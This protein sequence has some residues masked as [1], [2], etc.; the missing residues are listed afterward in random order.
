M[1]Y[2]GVLFIFFVFVGVNAQIQ[3]DVSRFKKVTKFKVRDIDDYQIVSFKIRDY[4]GGYT[5]L[6]DEDGEIVPHRFE[7]S[8]KTIDASLIRVEKVSSKKR[9]NLQD[10]VDGNINTSLI[11]DS[12]KDSVHSI[13]FKFK[14]PQIVSGIEI[15]LNENIIP[16]SNITLKTKPEDSDIW[17]SVIKD[18]AFTNILKCDSFETTELSLTLT[19][20]QL[21]GIA[22]IKILQPSKQKEKTDQ[23]IFFAYPQKEYTLYSEADF[24][25]RKFTFNYHPLR[26][27]IRTKKFNLKT[28]KL[29]PQ[30]N[31]DFDGDGIIDEQDLCPRIFDSK[32]LDIDHNQRGDLCEDPDGDGIISSIDNCPFF[33][34][35]DTQKDASPSCKQNNSKT[36]LSPIIFI[37]GGIFVFI[38]TIVIWFLVKVLRKH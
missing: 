1:K 12:S 5:V 36:F 15:I 30:Y 26:T 2:L 3:E 33:Y 34:N 24:G 23:L 19:T 17:L 14:V 16:P 38:L 13:I 22:D 31:P 7:P 6:F 27:D 28:A 11:F 35:P 37:L 32:N 25:Q 9:G 29:N 4:M 21:L 18:Q 8:F 10:L 20:K